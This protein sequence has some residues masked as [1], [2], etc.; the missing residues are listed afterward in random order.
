ML[1]F[2]VPTNIGKIL[3]IRMIP[4]AADITSSKAINAIFFF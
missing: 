1:G 2:I 3:T 4:N